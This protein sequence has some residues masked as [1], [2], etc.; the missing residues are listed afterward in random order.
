MEKEE[1][2]GSCKWKL[3]LFPR[4]EGDSHRHNRVNFFHQSVN[5]QSG[6]LHMQMKWPSYNAHHDE[7]VDIT[8]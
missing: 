3:Y 5:I 8:N 6:K 1:I 4:L 2:F 7:V